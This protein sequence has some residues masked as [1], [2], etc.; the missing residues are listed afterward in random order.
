MFQRFAE[1]SRRI[2]VGAQE[3]ARLLHHHHIGSEHLL[4]ALAQDA[5]DETVDGALAAFDLTSVAIREAHTPFVVND[6]TVERIRFL[7]EADAEVS[8][9]IWLV[10][11]PQPMILPAHAVREDGTWKV[12]RSTLQQVAQQARMFRRLPPPR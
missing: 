1:R 12:S 11:T 6:Q 5:D 4:V 7:D 3:E 9:G 2:V 8:V 10:D